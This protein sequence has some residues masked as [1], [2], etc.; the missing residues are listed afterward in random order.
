ML[1]DSTG[2]ERGSR[3]TPGELEKLELLSG[4][5]VTCTSSIKEV[6]ELLFYPEGLGQ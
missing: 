4:I 5:I 6:R 1:S 3:V 2:V